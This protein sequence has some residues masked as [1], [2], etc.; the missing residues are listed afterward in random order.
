M[1]LSRDCRGDHFEGDNN[2]VVWLFE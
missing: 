1:E 2:S